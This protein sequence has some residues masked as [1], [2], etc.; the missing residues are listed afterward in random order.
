LKKKNAELA[1]PP[2]CSDLPRLCSRPHWTVRNLG[3][4]SET[5]GGIPIGPSGASLTQWP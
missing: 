4:A 5:G 1:R 2:A 3:M